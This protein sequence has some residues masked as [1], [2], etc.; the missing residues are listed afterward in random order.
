MR[1]ASLGTISGVTGSP[2]SR[3][4]TVCE[5]EPEGEEGTRAESGS[6]WD[7]EVVGESGSI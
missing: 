6:G 4:V 2:G 1:A 7:G 5:N 3:K